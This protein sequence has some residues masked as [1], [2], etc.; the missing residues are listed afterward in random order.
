MVWVSF[1]TGGSVNLAHKIPGCFCLV[2]DT[3]LSF[4]SP[5]LISP[6][7]WTDFPT[8]RVQAPGCGVC[9]FVVLVLLLG[10]AT[11]GILFTCLIFQGTGTA[12]S[13]LF[14]PLFCDTYATIGWRIGGLFHYSNRF[15]FVLFSQCPNQAFLLFV[16]VSAESRDWSRVLQ[17]M[18][19]A[20]GDS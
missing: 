9:T 5:C 1:Y 4:S 11:L 16:G 17:R 8:L 3:F 18:Q 20:L 14:S 12:L 10:S 19:L 7:P 6:S 2:F 13:F 15:I